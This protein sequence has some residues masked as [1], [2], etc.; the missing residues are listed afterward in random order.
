MVSASGDATPRLIASGDVE[1]VDT[2]P[3]TSYADL[4]ESLKNQ[5]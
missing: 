3:V 5:A 1:P 2:G 4:F